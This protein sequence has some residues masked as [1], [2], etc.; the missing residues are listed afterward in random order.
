MGGPLPNPG[1]SNMSSIRGS[2]LSIPGGVCSRSFVAS[3]V[4]EGGGTTVEGG[5]EDVD[6][7]SQET[8]SCQ[9]RRRRKKSSSV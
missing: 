5:G 6:V 1:A 2:C 7:M 8:S 9:P 4:C 3:W